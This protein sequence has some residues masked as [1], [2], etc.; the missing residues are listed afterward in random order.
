M[1]IGV[2]GGS[3]LYDWGGGETPPK[4]VTLTTPFGE[5]SGPYFRQTLGKNEIIFLP[6]HGAGHRLL[7]SEI[8]YRANVF[9]FKKLGV[10][11]LISVSAVGSLR[12]EFK[13][14]HFAF[15]D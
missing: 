4:P 13:P 3:G 12:E 5:P 11:T 2:I 6:R 15:P 14:G 8:N 9:G 1:L 10:S 7:P